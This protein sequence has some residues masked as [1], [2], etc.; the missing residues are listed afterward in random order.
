MAE[1]SGGLF[2][3]ERGLELATASARSCAGQNVLLP[4]DFSRIVLNA[5]MTVTGIEPGP[6]RSTLRSC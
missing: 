5:Q 3:N 2:G 4:S 6:F 1:K